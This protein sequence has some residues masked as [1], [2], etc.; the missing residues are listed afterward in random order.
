MHPKLYLSLILSL[1]LSLLAVA[2]IVLIANFF[3]ENIAV[4][5]GNLL[6]IPIAGGFVM[7][8]VWVSL[9]FGFR[10]TYG[11][12]WLFFAIFGILWFIAEMIWAYNDVILGIDPYPSIADFFW[13]AGYPCVFSF[14]LLYIKPVRK[15]ISKKNLG[16][17]VSIGLVL[18]GLVFAVTLKTETTDDY[19]LYLLTISYPVLDTIILV[20]ALVGII[21]FFKGQVDLLWSMISLGIFL[22]VFADIGFFV[23]QYDF[24]YYTGH[25]IEIFFYW[26]YILYGFGAYSHLKIFRS[27]VKNN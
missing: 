24:T 27:T 4:L 2:S 14:L 3:G 9:R 1:I 19:G 8:A 10:G 25:P 16:L 5:T 22:T 17:A 18:I 15:G 11:K 6:Y 12:A 20:P 23:T 26:A 13:L 7:V 21:L